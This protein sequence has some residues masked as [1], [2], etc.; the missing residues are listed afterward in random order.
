[1]LAPWKKGYDQPRQHIKKQ[2]HYFANKGL[3]SQGYGFNSSH[4]WM[5]ELRF[6]KCFKTDCSGTSLAALVVKT[7][8]SNT[9]GASSIPGQGAKIPHASQPENQSINSWNNIVTHSIKTFKMVHIKKIFKK[10][11]YYKKKSLCWG[12]SSAKM[13]WWLHISVNIYKN[14]WITYFKWMD[15]MAC[16]LHINTAFKK[17]TNLILG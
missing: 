3:S 2:K 15:L 14:Q 8:P 12:T 5:W 9:E 4:V 13:W 7:P 11:F 1:M 10:I 6:L 16:K 17:L